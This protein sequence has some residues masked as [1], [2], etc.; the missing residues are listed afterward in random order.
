MAEKTGRSAIIEQ[1]LAD[2][3]TYMFG[4]PGIHAGDFCVAPFS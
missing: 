3:M 2:G 4:N 1:F